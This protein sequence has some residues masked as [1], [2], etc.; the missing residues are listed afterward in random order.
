MKY[1]FLYTELAEYTMQCLSAH[2]RF[3]PEDELHVVHYPINPEAPFK[4]E[5][6]ERLNLYSL[7]EFQEGE[8][9]ALA[10]TIQPAAVICSGWADRKYNEIASG[11]SK[12]GVPVILCFDNVYLGT[13]KQ[14]LFL[15]LARYIFNR[16]YKACWVPGIK[17]SLFAKKLGFSENRIFTGFYATDAEMYNGM[18]QKFSGGKAENFPKKFLCV[19][20]YI[21]QKGLEYLWRAFIEIADRKNNG[22]ELWCAGTGEGFNFRIEH[23][24]IHH[25]GFVQPNQFAGL[26]E[27]CGVF[28]LPSLFEPWGVA[29]NEFA[30]AGMPLLLSEKVGSAETFLINGQNGFSFKPAN[31]KD[32]KKKLEMIMNLSDQELLQMAEKS[33]ILG[34]SV[35]A[36]NWSDTLYQIARMRG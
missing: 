19:A 23:P 30:T 24:K 35:N 22:W 17:Q 12:R 14:R 9:H 28:V 25:L 4:F 13:L 10:D 33:H 27:K 5:K 16:R 36:K 3:H 32:I 34:D 18:Y 6:V 26:V 1:I 11:L 2:L 21:P 15:P 31:E 20:R 8:L 7:N 29:V